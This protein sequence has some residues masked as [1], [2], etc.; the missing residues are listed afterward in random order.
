MQAYAS[1]DRSDQ[2]CW[3]HPEAWAEGQHGHAVIPRIPIRRWGTLDDFGA[4]AVYL[5][6]DKSRWHTGEII[7]IEGGF[8]I[9]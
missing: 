1:R 3:S 4:I 8:S 2:V 7:K 6:R 5:M 9:F